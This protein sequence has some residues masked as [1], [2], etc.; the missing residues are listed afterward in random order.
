M[1]KRFKIW[2][3]LQINLRET[4]GLGQIPTWK[5]PGWKSQALVSGVRHRQHLQRSQNGPGGLQQHVNMQTDQQ[6]LQH[7]TVHTGTQLIYFIY[8]VYLT[9]FVYLFI[10]LFVYLFI[11]LFIC[12]FIYLFIWLDYGGDAAGDDEVRNSH[13]KIIVN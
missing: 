3:I 13:G 8:F 9:L 12:L 11:Y 7:Q 5:V 4:S 2:Q 6:A 1:Q 10:C